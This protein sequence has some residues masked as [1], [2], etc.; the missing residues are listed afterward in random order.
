MEKNGY[1]E[2]LKKAREAKGLKF[3]EV[4]KVLKVDPSYLIAMEEENAAV[5][6]RPVYMRLFLKT[7]A[8]YLKID[9]KE[10]LR[11]YNES[12]NF[13]ETRKDLINEPLGNKKSKEAKL[14]EAQAKK[15]LASTKAPF[16]LDVQK[17][18][19]LI[20][21][22]SSIAAVVIMIIVLVVV[23]FSKNQGKGLY[24][25]PVP[26]VMQ[27]TAKAK[28]DVWIKVKSDDKEEE[29]NLKIGQEKKWKDVQKIVFLIGNAGGVEFVVNG[30]NIGTIGDEG[31]VINGLVFESGKNWYIDKK[32]SFRSIKSIPISVVPTVA[33]TVTAQ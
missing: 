21:V 25:V 28:E 11:R 1:G 7:Y 26:V 24:V 19:N 17:N 14:L 16:E 10:I 3:A 6:E 4:Y 32:Q 27:V 8:V 31:E 9:Y 29:I 2:L 22:I 13:V 15:E 5:L 18:K 12:I 30:D 33:V 23:I 20:I